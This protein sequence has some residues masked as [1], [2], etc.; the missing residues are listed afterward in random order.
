[1]NSEMKIEKSLI[2]FAKPS[3]AVV[4]VSGSVD[5]ERLHVGVVRLRELGFP[6]TITD[7][8]SASWRYFAG[9][10]E[11]RL[12]GLAAALASDAQIVMFSRGGYGVSRI[13]HRIDWPRVAAS[14]KIFCGFSDIT[15]FSLAALATANLVTWAGPMAAVDFALTDKL[16]ERR[17][18]ETHFLGLVSAAQNGHAY[19]YVYPKCTS[20]IAHAPSTIIGTLWGTN[21]AMI[22]HLIGTPYM[23]SIDDGILVL[24]D[25]GEEPYAVERMFWQLKHSG[26]LNKQRAIILGDFADCEP[27]ANLRYPYNMTETIETLR[28]IAPCPVLTGFP[29]GHIPAKVTLPMGILAAL[30]IHGASYTLSTCS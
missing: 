21:L 16:P 13:L 9:T 27:D 5:N 30:S 29:F 11:Q 28:H 22:A 23:P 26:I 8:T 4:S 24:E 14:G 15:A 12:D 2:S 20:D 10:D 6:V 7:G 3:I 17:F 25:I 19:R 18:T 1:M